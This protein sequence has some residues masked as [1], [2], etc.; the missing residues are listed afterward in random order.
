[1]IECYKCKSQKRVKVVWMCDDC[2]QSK[3]ITMKELGMAFLGSIL[4]CLFFM[5]WIMV[6]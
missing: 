1:M 2:K 5:I 4:T 6:L 3:N